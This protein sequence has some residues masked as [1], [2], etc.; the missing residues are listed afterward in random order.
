MSHDDLTKRLG[1][2]AACAFLSIN[3]WTGAP[4][5][6]V[7][8]GSQFSGE[9]TLDMAAVAVVVVVLAVTVLTMAVA[10]TWLS[11][12][13]DE[14]IGRPPGER[15]ATWLRSVRAEERGHMS[16]KVG[17]TVVER[18]VMASVWLAVV[19]LLVWLVF[20]AGSMAPSA[21]R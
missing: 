16:S 6:A 1:I 20:F 17:V 11:N 15:R 8:V 5:L 14:L 18:I 21:L 10:L 12:K 13:Y 3:I 19:A 7:W 9:Q 2:V 4:L